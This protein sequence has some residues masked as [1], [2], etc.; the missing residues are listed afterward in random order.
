MLMIVILIV[1]CNFSSGKERGYS[2]RRLFAIGHAYS[3]EYTSENLAIKNTLM[4]ICL[5][6]VSRKKPRS[7]SLPL[8]Y[9]R[10]FLGDS[11]EFYRTHI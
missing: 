2:S 10:F 3:V 1:T 8:L 11:I 7:H 4:L 9:G 6:L 5:L